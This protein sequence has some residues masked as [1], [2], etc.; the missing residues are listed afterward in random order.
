[1]AISKRWMD[2]ESKYREWFKSQDNFVLGQT[3]FVKV[4]SDLW[5]A[6]IIGQHKI[7][8]D[9]NGNSPIR[10]DAVAKGLERVAQFAN[11]I[12]YGSYA[13]NWLWSGRWN[14]G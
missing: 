13:P 9:E 7:N 11:E 4:E 2:P 5:V 6:N 1:M 3:Q 12:M 8:K 14:L 10:Y